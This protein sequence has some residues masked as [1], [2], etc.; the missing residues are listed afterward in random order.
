MQSVL[1]T[2]LQTDPVGVEV[3]AD[4]RWNDG[5]MIDERIK[6][7]PHQQAVRRRHKLSIR[8]TDNHQHVL[9]TT[10]NTPTSD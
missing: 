10:D 6:V 3:Q 9:A 4:E 5:E 2:E 8:T 7:N 1:I